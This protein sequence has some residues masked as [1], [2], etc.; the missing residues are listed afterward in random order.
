MG[1]LI[2][3]IIGVAFVFFIVH[4]TKA[5]KSYEETQREVAAKLNSKTNDE[6]IKEAVGFMTRAEALKQAELC[7]DDHTKNAIL[8]NTYKGS[9]PERR[10]D[11]GWLS[12]YDDLRIL[13]V[14]GMNYCTGIGRYK[15]F[16]DVALVPE[17]Q[18]EF[19]PNAI[20]VI[21]SDRHHLGYVAA[22]QTDFV[23]S[24]THDM[25]PY[26]CKCDIYECD[27]ND[28]EKYYEG[29]LYIVKN[30]ESSH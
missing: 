29:F 12:I 22:H 13:K 7:G 9:W 8:N 30:K 5:A 4:V 27:N 10:D 21:A 14:A 24:L 25:F 28:D 16:I 1:T 15:G 18:N 26:R 2:F 3:I 19:D 23:R 11:G 17:P 20:K 6:L